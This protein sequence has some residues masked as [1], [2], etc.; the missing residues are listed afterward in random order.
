VADM[1]ST[2]FSEYQRSID[3]LLQ[4][5]YSTQQ[6]IYQCMEQGQVSSAVAQDAYNTIEQIILR[7]K[8]LGYQITGGQQGGSELIDN[9][10]QNDL[11]LL[12]ESIN[13]IY[14]LMLEIST[15]NL[16]YFPSSGGGLIGDAAAEVSTSRTIYSQIQNSIRILQNASDSNNLSSDNL[17]TTTRAINTLNANVLI[18]NSYG[19]QTFA[20]NYST[21]HFRYKNYLRIRSKVVLQ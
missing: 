17:N 18:L 15:Q 11:L 2:L 20:Y 3:Y 21:S 14:P 5:Q 9:F 7:L 6:T 8:V 19:H 12:E 13:N 1:R 4:Q 10:I 16:S